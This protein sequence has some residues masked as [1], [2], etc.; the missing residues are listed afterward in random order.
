MCSWRATST[1]WGH[2]RATGQPS[3]FKSAEIS[4]FS[5]FGVDSGDV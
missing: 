2:F 5:G 4:D 1:D 3:C